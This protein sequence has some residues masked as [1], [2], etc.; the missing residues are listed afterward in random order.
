M[1]K[2]SFC[3]GLWGVWEAL[4]GG[5]DFGG[6]GVDV[7][8]IAIGAP[9]A[10][11]LDKSAPIDS[12]KQLCKTVAIALHALH[13]VGLKDCQQ[14]MRR[15]GFTQG[16]QRG[17]QLSG[18]MSVILQQHQLAVIAAVAHAHAPRHAREGGKGATRLRFINTQHCCGPH[19]HGGINAYV[20][21][22]QG[23][24]AV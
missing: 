5:G 22:R 18:M 1:W 23:H 20:P 8:R 16:I 4:A 24:L 13:A 10:E 14:A 9:R 11:W 15:I 17:L 2:S 3:D 21:S 19:G 7:R 6:D 12:R